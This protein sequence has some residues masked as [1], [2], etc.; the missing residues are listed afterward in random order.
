MTQI[1]LCAPVYAKSTG[2]IADGAVAIDHDRIMA[3]GTRD[4]MLAYTTPKTRIKYYPDEALLIPAFCDSHQH[5]LS[6]IRGRAERLSL[7]DATSLSEVFARIATKSK[8]LPAGSWIIADGHDQGRYVEQRH[9]TRNE[10]DAIT[11]HHPLIIHRACHHVAIANSVALDIAHIT[12][13]TPHPIGGRIGKSVDGT[14]NGILEESARALV[15][16]HIALPV[17]DWQ[18]YIPQAVREYHKRGITAIG[19]AAIGHINGLHDLHTMQTAYVDGRLPLR[20]SYMGYG[21]VADSWL[22]GY[23]H[24]IADDWQNAPIIKFFVDGTLGGESAWLSQAYRNNSSTRGY[25]LFDKQ[26]LCNAI[27]QAHDAHYQVAIH[28]IGD[29]AVAQVLDAYEYVLLNTPRIDHRHRIEHVEVLHAGLAQRFAA[30][31]I[32]AAVQPLFT[33]YEESDIAQ[34]PDALLPYAHAWK[35]LQ[36]HHVPL[37]FGSDNPV[38]PD[39]APIK[40]IAAAVTRT[41][42]RG[43]SINPYQQISW[44]SAIDAYTTTAAWSLQREHVFGDLR[45]G[46]KADLVILDRQLNNGSIDTIAVQETWLDGQ[47]VYQ[48]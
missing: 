9:P 32:I 47:C 30:L 20:V 29:A 8:T 34:V 37:A 23:Q 7:W 17:I 6:Y 5:F 11:P 15:T 48:R 18:A 41:N 31:G 1:L 25:P 38:V 26:T 21:E 40:G 4:R 2:F 43:T 28:A 22:N 12:A 24:I 33:W 44:Q 45:S 19:E 46:L 39:F 3:V 35:T 10:L 27:A 42:Y 36:D 13:D 16:R 14:P